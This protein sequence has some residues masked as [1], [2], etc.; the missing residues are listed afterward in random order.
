MHKGD[1][2]RSAPFRILL[3]GSVA[4]LAISALTSGA[5]ASASVVH[6]QE[7]PSSIVIGFV[8]GF[9]R[10]DNPHH[11]PVIFAQRLEQGAPSGTYVQ[12]FENRH[13]RAAYNTIIRLLDRNHDGVLSE[14]E[15]AQARIILYGQSWGA[16]TVL[17]LARQLNRTGIPVLLTVQVDTVS[18]LWRN[19]KTIPPNV[20]AAA[21]F[22]QRHGLVRGQP[23][24]V[25]ADPARTQIVGNFLFDYKESPVKCE[26]YS[27][28]D[29]HVTPSHMQIECDPSVWTQVENLVRQRLE[30]RPA[31]V[32]AAQP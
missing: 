5:F 22:Y 2:R 29:R 19:D 30:P 17:L 8:G 13:R 9:V 16:A 24:I 18:R 15:K 7:T 6:S 31:A 1:M 27:W 32:A 12:V 10:H 11:G 14:D 25:A 20:R 3:A 28:L 4:I 26:G 23:H 21:N